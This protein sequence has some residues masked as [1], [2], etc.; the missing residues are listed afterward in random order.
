MLHIKVL[1]KPAYALKLV[2]RGTTY[3][4]ANPASIRI[5]YIPFRYKMMRNLYETRETTREFSSR[6]APETRARVST[7]NSSLSVDPLTFSSIKDTYRRQRFDK[8]R[9]AARGQNIEHGTRKGTW[10]TPCLRG[11]RHYRH[12]LLIH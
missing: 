8:V 3:V 7:L 10:K 1:S 9:L 5:R 11:P 4:H 2:F 6:V 12:Q